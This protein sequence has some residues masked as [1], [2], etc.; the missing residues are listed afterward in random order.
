MFAL[1]IW[2]T[3]TQAGRVV[4]AERQ[5]LNGRVSYLAQRRFFTWHRNTAFSL[6]PPT[7]WRKRQSTAGRAVTTVNPSG[8]VFSFACDGHLSR[9]FYGNHAQKT[10]EAYKGKTTPSPGENV[11]D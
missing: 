3:N 4:D 7:A 10:L 2:L 5:K 11:S 6:T 1:A 8:H 9:F